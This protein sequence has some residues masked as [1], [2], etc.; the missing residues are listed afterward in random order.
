VKERESAGFAWLES[1]L[2]AKCGVRACF[3][4]RGGGYSASPY[5]ALNLGLHVGDDEIAVLNNR[6][7]YWSALELDPDSPVGARQVHGS[8]VMVVTR[9]DRGRGAASWTHA[10]AGTDGLI[11][12]DRGVPVFGLAADCHLVALAAPEGG[13]VAVLHAGWR[14]LLG[15][16]ID[17]G[18]GLL[19][20]LVWKKPRDLVAFVGPGLGEGRFEVRGD[21]EAALAKAWGADALKEFVR[22]DGSR[23]LFRY[24]AAVRR[25]LESAGIP[26]GNVECAGECTATRSDRYYS[27]RASGG[28]TGRM[29]MTVWIP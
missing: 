24:E 12:L 18:V 14:G 19:A 17:R 1:E 21:F 9:N 10:L 4:S 11:T 8:R 27:H 13:G 2:L 7:D 25:A 5:A 20:G 28:T 3:S 6:L 22:G 29:S 15:G 23:R 16:I 26:V